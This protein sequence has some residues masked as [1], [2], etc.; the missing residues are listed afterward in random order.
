MTP[1]RGGTRFPHKLD[2]IAK[3]LSAIHRA[4]GAVSDKDLSAAGTTCKSPTYQLTNNLHQGIF[5]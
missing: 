2:Q 4:S 1:L 3:V 5:A